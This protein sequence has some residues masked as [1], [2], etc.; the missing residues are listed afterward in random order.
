VWWLECSL[1]NMKLVFHLK[2]SIQSAHRYHN[3]TF[4]L[5][6]S[7]GVVHG[8]STKRVFSLGLS[9]S[10]ALGVPAVLIFFERRSQHSTIRLKLTR[11]ACRRGQLS[12]VGGISSRICM[13]R[14]SA[15]MSLSSCVSILCGFQVSD[16]A[17]FL[18]VEKGAGD[19]T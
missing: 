14:A 5:H 8:K 15:M 1:E 11:A 10:G 6:H 16:C 4:R 3:R 7:L 18:D 13:A 19:V 9:S 17:L 12:S 2:I